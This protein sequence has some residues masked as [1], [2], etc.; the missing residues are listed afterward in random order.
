MVLRSLSA[1]TVIQHGTW[2]Y[3]EQGYVSVFT[4]HQGI[5]YSTSPELFGA[6]FEFIKMLSGHCYYSKLHNH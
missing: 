3:N 4:S 2:F 6:L 1:M 5:N